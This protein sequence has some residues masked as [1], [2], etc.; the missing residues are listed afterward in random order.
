M[1]PMS[2]YLT[3]VNQ[4]L[5]RVLKSI[6]ETLAERGLHSDSVAAEAFLGGRA[7]SEEAGRAEHVGTGLNAP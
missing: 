1:I 2:P 6:P 5:N 3:H 7:P 4:T